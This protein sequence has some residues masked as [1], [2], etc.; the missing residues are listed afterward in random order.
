MSEKIY[1]KM[2]VGFLVAHIALILAALISYLVVGELWLSLSIL[3]VSLVGIAFSIVV[4]FTNLPIL[5]LAV[6]AGYI[7]M[8]TGFLN[9][10]TVGYNHLFLIDAIFAIVGG[11]A[12]TV[13]S[14]VFKRKIKRPEWISVICL[15]AVVAVSALGFGVPSAMERNAGSVGFARFQVPS[16]VDSVEVSDADKG[17]VEDVYYDTKH[18]ATDQSS[19]QKRAQVYLPPHYDPNENY[20]ILYLLHGTGDDEVYW[21]TTNHQN[22]VML[23]NLITMHAIKPLIVVTPTWYVGNDCADDLDKLTWSFKDELR[24]DLMPAIEKKYSTFTNGK[25]GENDFASTRDHRA[26]AGLSRGSVTTYHSVFMESLDY[27]SY[28]G[29]FSGSRTSAEQLMAAIEK[30]SFKNLSIHYYYAA[31]GTFDF[32]EPMLYRQYNDIL[33]LGLN[34]ENTRFDAVP[35]RY[36]SMGNWHVNLYNY[37]QGIFK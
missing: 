11:L 20:N 8:D 10:T 30:N 23:D 36:H 24:N 5:Y 1:P 32:A 6:A 26:F 29:T 18:Y 19:V 9:F 25:T 15:I 12:L 34:I 35:F 22:K 2:H 16:F 37:L 33:K 4:F 7:V 31:A 21:L 13:L 27:F 17:K 14:I 28:L 3:S